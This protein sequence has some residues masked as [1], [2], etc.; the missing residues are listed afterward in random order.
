MASASS[1]NKCY[2]SGNIT[3]LNI[4]IA[5]NNFFYAS[6]KVEEKGLQ[7]VNP[8]SDLSYSWEH[9]MIRDIKLLFDCDYV[10]MQKDFFFSNGALIELFISIILKKKIIYESK[11]Q[12]TM[13]LLITGIVQLIVGLV[14]AVL[15]ASDFLSRSNRRRLQSGDILMMLLLIVIIG[16]GLIMLIFK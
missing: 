8:M 13:V 7:P 3:G 5:R 4:N 14:F 2:I 6:K 12:K 1:N 9:F 11:F 10:F 16:G 15:Y